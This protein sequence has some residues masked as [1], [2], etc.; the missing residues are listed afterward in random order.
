[1]LCR[2]ERY[3]EAWFIFHRYDRDGSATIDGAELAEILVDLKMH[4]GRSRR[5]DEQ[6]REWCD[7]E[8]KKN[9]VN[10]DGVLSFDEFLQSVV[11]GCQHKP[12]HP[13]LMRPFGAC[14]RLALSDLYPDRSW[15]E[16]LGSHGRLSTYGKA[17]RLLS[18]ASQ[19]LQ[20]VCL[21]P[22]LTM[23]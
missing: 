19:V 23:G 13:T 11:T 1:M 21:A 6:M 2:F 16:Q 18:I 5:S 3:E 9:D 7:R 17:L 20:Q 22:P 8:L 10:G 15:T 14:L 12:R 4:V